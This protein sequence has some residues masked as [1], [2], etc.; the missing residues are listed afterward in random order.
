MSSPPSV[1]SVGDQTGQA[2][3]L[4]Q[5]QIGQGIQ[6]GQASGNLSN[7]TSP[8]GTISYSTN[9]NTMNAAQTYSPMEQALFNA[10]AGGFQPQAMGAANAGMGS[11]INSTHGT[12]MPNLSD[13]AG[14]LTGQ[15]VGQQTAAVEPQMAWQQQN[16][17]NQLRNQGLMPGSDAYNRAMQTMY[18]GQGQAITAFQAQD[19]PIAYQQAMQNYM[20]PLQTSQT[21]AQMGAPSALQGTWLGAPT[22][23]VAAPNLGQ[24]LQGITGANNL[25]YNAQANQF[26]S[27]TNA[28]G[29]LG[30]LFG[31]F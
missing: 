28:I 18:A 10:F 6:A 3:A 17:D 30:G 20:L 7:Q 15:L 25:Q 12:G 8:L 19:E 14:G 24:M 27:M 31:G 11:F 16:L 5:Q 13:T 1:P 22:S 2:A 9:G 29:A 23:Q 4:G 21:E 26:G